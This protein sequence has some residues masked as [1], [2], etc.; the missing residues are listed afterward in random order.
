MISYTKVRR[1]FTQTISLLA[2]V[3]A[4]VY[5]CVVVGIYFA[6]RTLTAV[7]PVRTKTKGPSHGS[8]MPYLASK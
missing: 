6:M 2:A 4:M 1:F 7:I 8:V 5:L 3:I